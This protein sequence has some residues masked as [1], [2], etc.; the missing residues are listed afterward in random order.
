MPHCDD[1]RYEM[2]H[3]LVEKVMNMWYKDARA[4]GAGVGTGDETP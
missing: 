2:P 3:G 4:G 1:A